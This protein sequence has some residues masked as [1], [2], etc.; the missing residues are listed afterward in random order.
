MSLPE[1]LP[2]LVADRK[3]TK[4]QGKRARDAYERHYRRLLGSMSP[5]AAAAEASEA[6][7][8]QI[9]R[10]NA[11]ARRQTMLQVEAQR[12]MQGDMARY[13]GDSYTAASALLGSDHNAPYMSVEA[14]HRAILGRAHAYMTD[15][16]FKHSRDLLGRVR[17]RTGLDDLVRERFGEDSGNASAKEL[18]GAWEQ[19]SEYLRL[20][21]NRAGGAIARRMDWGLPQGHDMM[22]VRAAGYEPWRDFILPRLDLA[23]MVDEASGMPFTPD[24]AEAAL[25]D[26]WET[27]RTDG[28][29]KREPGAMG[30]GKAANRHA[31]PR[32][33]LFKSGKDWLAY[34]ERFGTG[35]A[36]DVM[37]GHL[38]GMAREIALMER[39]GPN[40]AASLK[41]LQDSLDKEAH[42]DL[43]PG[44]QAMDAMRS[45]KHRLGDLYDVVS[46]QLNSPVNETWARRMGGVRSFLT[47][48]LLGSASLSALSDVGFQAVT[49]AYN[50]L[51]ITGA[52]TGYLKLFR[53]LGGAERQRLAVRLGLI[54]EEASHR[55]ASLNRY[56]DGT[57]GPEVMMRMSDAVLRLSGLSPW[58]QVGRWAFGMETL[59]HLADVAGKDWKALDPAFRDMLERYGIDGG[60]WEKIRATDTYKY[61]GAEFL[62]PDDVADEA[63]GDALLR[64]V[65]TE[66]DYAVPTVTARAKAA[67]SFGQRPGTLGG[68]VLRNTA[69]FKS[70]GVSMLLT[71]GAR[72]MSE[73]PF[74]RAGYFAGLT[75]TT[76][77]LGALGLQLYEAANGRDFMDMHDPWFWPK[78]LLKGGGFGIFGDFL[79]AGVQQNRFGGGPAETLAGPVVSAGADVLRSGGKVASDALTPGK[80]ANPGKEAVKLLKRYTP[81][82]SL[83][84]ARLGFERFLLDGLSKQADPTY[85]QSWGRMEE[86]AQQQGQEYWWRPG[87]HAPERAPRVARKPN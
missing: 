21:F 60:G 4:E 61:K 3:I 6:A 86:K 63:L 12:R 57:R 32:F 68:E 20:R 52:M 7:I 78:A 24:T 10:E 22:K 39:M 42:L 37:M 14:Q 2:G 47:S 28:W 48:S 38:D 64:M 53:T 46:G 27:I 17:D 36:F 55:A 18:A 19:A 44:R 49:R 71:H 74:T 1:C 66:T 50:G 45:G 62:R 82:G 75:M 85:W 35:N 81:G 9:E 58:T 8:S 15:V 59:G 51:P 56:V 73:E 69:L 79:G 76:T 29:N 34:Q 80:Q 65:L 31:D 72:M 77:L 83:F 16:L 41:W 13:K 40:P 23:R 84:Y 67:L 25:R 70:F 11:L 30:K 87:E 26:V 5:E 43:S 33:L 54:A